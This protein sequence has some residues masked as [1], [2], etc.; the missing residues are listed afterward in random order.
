MEII[1]RSYDKMS[2]T[3]DLFCTS[4][5]RKSVKTLILS[6]DTNFVRMQS[7]NN[8]ESCVS[9]KYNISNMPYFENIE[10]LHF[11]HMKLSHVLDILDRHKDCLQNLNLLSLDS[12]ATDS[13]SPTW[14]KLYFSFLYLIRFQYQY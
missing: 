1:Q 10:N 4:K 13:A 12:I 6:I 2:H 14:V 8:T 9:S 3:F 11:L 5:I 7:T